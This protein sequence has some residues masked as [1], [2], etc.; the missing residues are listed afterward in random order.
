M[1]GAPKRLH[2]AEPAAGVGVALPERVAVLGGLLLEGGA[3]EGLDLDAVALLNRAPGGVGLGEQHA[4]VE[5]EDAGIGTRREDEL[6]QHRL[7]LLERAGQRD[8]RM[9]RLEGGGD[10]LRSGE[11]LGLSGREGKRT[12]RGHGGLSGT[13]SGLLRPSS[14][15]IPYVL[16]KYY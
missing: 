16:Q 2:L 10:Q 13:G 9:E 12:G 4:G 1:E 6:K 8:L 14:K 11:G 7:F 15:R 3:A 5:G